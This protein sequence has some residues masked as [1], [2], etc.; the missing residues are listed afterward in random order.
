MG[1]VTVEQLISF[2]V[3]GG[4]LIAL[5]N[6]IMTAVKNHGEASEKKNAPIVK[7]T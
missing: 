6:T 1:T 5:Y 2:V 4:V 3:V 7:L